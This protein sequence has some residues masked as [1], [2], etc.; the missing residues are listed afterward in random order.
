MFNDSAILMLGSACCIWTLM[1]V[2]GMY[3]RGR[4]EV[5]TVHAMSREEDS[6]TSSELVARRCSNS[7]E[8]FRI[9]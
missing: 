9:F 5:Y 4:R 7:I 2:I 1:E 6:S 3:L 8:H